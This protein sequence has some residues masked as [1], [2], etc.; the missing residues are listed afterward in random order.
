MR[1]AFQSTEEAYGIS[2]DHWTGQCFMGVR[3]HW[4]RST[5]LSDAAPQSDVG[6]RTLSTNLELVCPRDGPTAEEP[7]KDMHIRNFQIHCDYRVCPWQWGDNL[8]LCIWV[9]PVRTAND[10]HLQSDQDYA[11][12]GAVLFLKL[13]ALVALVRRIQVIKMEYFPMSHLT[14]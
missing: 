12:W 2:R 4:E 7:S 9:F 14:A 1:S 6:I 8:G 3:L 10:L 11:L 13:H 5:C